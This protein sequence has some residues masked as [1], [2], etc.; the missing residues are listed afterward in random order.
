M[1]QSV[2]WCHRRKLTDGAVGCQ[3]FDCRLH[4]AALIDDIAVGTTDLDRAVRDGFPLLPEESIT[5]ILSRVV[6]G[7]LTIVLFE[8][9]ID[10]RSPSISLPSLRQLRMGVEI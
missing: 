9:S 10:Q 6:R 4:Q 3:N 5:K 2:I 7:E 8:D 1:R